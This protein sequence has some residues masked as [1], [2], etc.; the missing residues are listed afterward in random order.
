MT[1]HVTNNSGKQLYEL[2]T[3]GE[4]AIA[5]YET[6]GDAVVFTHT[7][8]PPALEGRGVGS[9]LIQGALDDVRR[10][11]GHVIAECGFVAA[12]L[13]R[14][15]DQQDLMVWCHDGPQRRH[16]PVSTRPGSH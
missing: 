6:R 7:L 10:Q 3:G 1:E 8:V 4:I 2:A 16:P 12:Y 15:P 14:H 13:Q 9:R 11:G 5:A